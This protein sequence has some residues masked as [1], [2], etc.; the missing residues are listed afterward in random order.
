MLGQE[1]VEMTPEM[2]LEG[3]QGRGWAVFTL[4]SI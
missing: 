2:I 4:T 1:G 3:L